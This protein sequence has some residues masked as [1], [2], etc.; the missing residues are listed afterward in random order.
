MMKK[1][2]GL[3]SAAALVLVSGGAAAQ[4]LHE[5][6]I[7]MSIAGGKLT[8][9][10]NHESEYG[11]GR[12]IFEGSLETLLSGPRYRTTDPGFDSE[13]GTFAPADILYF[14]G[15]GSLAFWDGD[16]WESSVPNG[17]TIVIRDSLDEE[18]VVGTAGLSPSPDFTG[19]ISDGGPTGQIHQH[20][21]FTLQRAVSGLPAPAVGAYRVGLQLF[22]EGYTD[23]DEFYLVLNRGLDDEAFEASVMAMAV[24]E[25]ETYALMAAGL[26]LVTVVA[27][28]S[29]R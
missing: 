2:I 25:P 20:L 1:M 22:A 24:P 18:L 23:S 27:R 7:E 4:H 16:S 5:G 14:R 17:E 13:P 11:T 6:D 12:Q 28:R 15:W 9:A 10:G 26:A 19:A 3:L 29:K 8:V 21:A